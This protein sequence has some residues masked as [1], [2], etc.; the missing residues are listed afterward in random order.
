M[1]DPLNIQ[2]DGDHYKD[3]PIQ[4]IEY[5]QKNQ[6]NACESFAIKHITRHKDKGEGVTDLKKAIHYLQMLLH[7]EYGIESDVTYGGL[8]KL[9]AFSLFE[10]C[11]D[12]AD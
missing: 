4:P 7:M 8:T 1:S 10:T 9:D 6:L 12:G 3:R 2:H 5:C 11:P